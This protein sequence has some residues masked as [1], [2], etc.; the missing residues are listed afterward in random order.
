MAELINLQEADKFVQMS[1]D[2]LA[3]FR[4]D[5]VEYKAQNL[6]VTWSNQQIDDLTN[7]FNGMLAMQK[8]LLQ[9]MHNNRVGR[10]TPRQPPVSVDELRAKTRASC[11]IAFQDDRRSRPKQRAREVR[12]AAAAACLQKKA[13]APGGKVLRRL[14]SW[15]QSASL[16]RSRTGAVRKY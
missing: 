9:V 13:T 16:R 2:Y 11:T 4:R 7:L 8:A 15:P 12:R 3:S 14:K 5:V 1:H 10:G 6:G